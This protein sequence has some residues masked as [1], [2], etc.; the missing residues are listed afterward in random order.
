MPDR[1]ALAWFVFALS[2]LACDSA[3]PSGPIAVHPVIGQVHFNG[4]PVSN[5]IIVFHPETPTPSPPT[6]KPGEA[7]SDRTIVPTGRTDSEGRFQVHTYVGDD[8][9][10]VGHYKV[11][12]VLAGSSENRDF[13]AKNSAAVSTITLPAKYA[14]PALSGLTATVEAGDNVIPPFEL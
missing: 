9:A 12:V 13:L 3:P 2:G 4:K 11:T 7:S 6:P 10:P 1:L 5:A 14:N 8:G